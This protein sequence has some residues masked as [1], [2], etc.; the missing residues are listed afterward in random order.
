L[1]FPITNEV[2]PLLNEL[3]RIVVAAGGRLYLAKDARQRPATFEAGYPTVAK[4]RNVR[5]AIGAE[6]R[7]ASRLSARLGI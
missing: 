5:R 3:D 7:V 2:F 4:F 6:G 1:D